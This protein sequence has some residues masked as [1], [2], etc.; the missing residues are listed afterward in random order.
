MSVVGN[1]FWVDHS[2][3]RDGTGPDVCRRNPL[4]QTVNF[5]VRGEGSFLTI[6]REWGRRGHRRAI[7]E[8]IK[9]VLV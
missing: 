1:R 3:E 4:K 8:T 2:W 7:Y 6:G 9:G 5:L